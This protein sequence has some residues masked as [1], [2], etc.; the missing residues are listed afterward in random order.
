MVAKTNVQM[1]EVRVDRV[2]ERDDKV[3][4]WSWPGVCRALCTKVVD[5]HVELG[6][7]GS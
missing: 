1:R 4:A 6:H 2:S 5:S 7:H 3:P